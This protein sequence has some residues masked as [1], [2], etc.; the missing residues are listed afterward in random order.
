MEDFYK[1]LLQEKRKPATLQN[2][3]QFHSHLTFLFV[4]LAGRYFLIE[5]NK[6][7]FFLPPPQIIISLIINSFLFKDNDKDSPIILAVNS[8]V[9]L[10]HLY[11][12]PLEKEI[13]KSF[14]S[15]EILSLFNLFV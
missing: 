13:S 11:D 3:H 15:N 4:V 1:F 6:I 14:V 7:L 5:A 10:H 9:L 2:H 8:L 12:K